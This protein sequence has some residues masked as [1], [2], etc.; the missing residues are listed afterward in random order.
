MGQSF[1]SPIANLVISAGA[2]GSSVISGIKDA[3]A[4]CIFAPASPATLTGSIK[5]Q[6]YPTAGANPR[7]L[8][9]G[10]ADITIN[11]GDAVVLTDVVYPKIR[12]LSS[13]AEG[14]QRTFNVTKRWED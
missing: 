2:T 12:L 11:A 10:G 4:L 9:S 13:L 3:R 8:T 14:A 6:A 5:I 1:V 7:D